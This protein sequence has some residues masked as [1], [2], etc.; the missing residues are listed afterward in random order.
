MVY[1]CQS[2]SKFRGKA[3]SLS[4]TTLSIKGLIVT[5]CITKLSIKG[6]IVTISITT[7]GIKVL[8]V[9]LSMNDTQH[10]DTQQK[11]FNCDA[12]YE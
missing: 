11:W 10:N 1:H 2:C 8:I 5:L 3:R 12:Q 4:I 7:L 6:L 9:M